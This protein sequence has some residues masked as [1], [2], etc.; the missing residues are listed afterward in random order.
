[1][2]K[3]M[4][5]PYDLGFVWLRSKIKYGIFGTTCYTII[6]FANGVWSNYPLCCIFNF[7]YITLVK[8]VAAGAYVRMKYKDLVYCTP[9][10]K[11]D[12][13]ISTPGYVQCEKCLREKRHV[14]QSKTRKGL[15]FTERWLV[16][17]RPKRDWIHINQVD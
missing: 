8:R 3:E 2:E 10:W 17:K 7:L 16:G 13:R 12:G 6:A 15:I 14:P 1:M 5:Q 9:D 4:Q 11:I